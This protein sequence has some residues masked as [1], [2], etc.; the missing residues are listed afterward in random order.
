MT[1]TPSHPQLYGYDILIDSALK[2]WLLEVN[3]SPSLSASDR[4][5]WTLKFGMLNVGA[6]WVTCVRRVQPVQP[7][8]SQPLFALQLRAPPACLRSRQGPLCAMCTTSAILLL[9]RAVA[10]HSQ[11]MLDIVDLEGRRE[12]GKYPTKQG[13]FDLIWDA[14]PGPGF[15]R[16]TSLVTMLGCYNERDENQ[17]RRPLAELVA[18]DAAAAGGGGAGGAAGSAGRR[19]LGEGAGSRSGGG[20]FNVGAAL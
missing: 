19:R 5:D 20:S 9:I 17:L 11:D 4:A 16:P 6:A 18:E 3:A 2:P 13:G 14:G 7:A 10:L 15:D 12:A 8:R 1:N